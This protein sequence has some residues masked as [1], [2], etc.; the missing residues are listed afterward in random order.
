MRLIETS[1]LKT[2]AG[3]KAA[4][5]RFPHLVKKLICAV[6]QPEKLQMPSGDAVWV[7]GF[8]GVVRRRAGWAVRS[9]GT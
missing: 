6:I 3:S 7:P 8:D 1:N 4:E 9:G 5:S 2:W